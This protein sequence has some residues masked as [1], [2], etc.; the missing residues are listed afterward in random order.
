[1]QMA[2]SGAFFAKKGVE[3]PRHSIRGNH[4]ERRTSIMNTSFGKLFTQL[5][6]VMGLALLFAGSASAKEVKKGEIPAD[7]LA[8]SCK[9][10]PWGVTVWDLDEAIPVMNNGEKVLWIDTRPPSFYEKGTV[11]G[12]LVME[13]NKG[14]EEGNHLNPKMLEE[15]IQKAGLTKETAKI[16]FF[17]QGPE[18]HRSY[19]A[20]FVAVTQWGYS[21][22]NII[23]FR[24]GYPELFKGVKASAGLKRKAKTY[25]SESAVSQL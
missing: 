3:L 11:R 6:L 10:L 4:F 12:A 19:N 7:H 1:M 15:A 16:A 14:G 2:G 23:W 20:A 22:K 24:D 17:C 8:K 5:A 9:T 18:C 13:Y 21:P 25:L